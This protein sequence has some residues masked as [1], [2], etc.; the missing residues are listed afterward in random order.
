M[1]NVNEIAARIAN[2]SI[3][4]ANDA[5]DLRLLAEKYPYTQLF[6]ILYLQSLKQAGDVHFEDELKKHSFR[7]TDRAQLFQLIESS[8][9]VSAEPIIEERVI[10]RPIIEREEEIGSEKIALNEFQAAGIESE[11]VPE[12][13]SLDL[14]QEE[15]VK[16]NIAFSEFEIAEL[17]NTPLEN[18]DNSEFEVTRT[19]IEQP[20]LNATD[21]EE[22]LSL[23]LDEDEVLSE[24]ENADLEETNSDLI[25]AEAWEE[26]IEHG[27]E[28][29]A[30]VSDVN[31]THTDLSTTREIVEENTVNA[32]DT[33]TQSEQLEE[34]EEF[35]NS[36]VDDS[37][38]VL[39]DELIEAETW[40]E[41]IE[42]GEDET[43]SEE[44]H[45]LYSIEEAFKEE[46]KPEIDPL[47]QTIA[48]HVYAANYRLDGLS[49]EE[50]QKLKEKQTNSSIETDF[51][52]QRSEKK[53]SASFTNWLHANT[54][55]EAPDI[56]P[57][58]PVIVPHFSEFDP[59]K[60][61]FGE[62]NRPKQEFFSA[63][64]KAKKSLTEE[65]L[66]VSETLAKV[67]SMQGNYPKAIAAYEQLMLTIP[68]KKSFFASLIE[69]LK[70]KLNT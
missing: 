5:E 30:S 1:L 36:D 63:P 14:D 57:V 29:D 68:E 46:V 35:N 19:E 60:S 18:P 20:V 54:N 53:E 50:E 44:K 10:E 12:E 42:H 4:K 62:Q 17:G 26:T 66:P 48:H 9:S 33:G 8:H 15:T 31:E 49:D 70:T 64:K 40:E 27:A 6:S 23:E 34:V 2:P 39:D 58:T 37:E 43:A 55:Y 61:L 51:I 41:T 56:A 67:Y 21:T 25:E 7:I 52:P 11:L 16:E 24:S 32:P 38:E 28:I 69:E 47:E 22:N 45:E 59:S 3:T 65:T 13:N